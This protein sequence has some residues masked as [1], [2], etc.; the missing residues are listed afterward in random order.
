MSVTP[1][2]LELESG[3]QFSFR[4]KAEK[5]PELFNFREN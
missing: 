2:E 4:Q 5:E 3:F 1:K